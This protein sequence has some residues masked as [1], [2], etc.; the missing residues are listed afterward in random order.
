MGTRLSSSA[1][2]A[3]LWGTQETAA[4]F[5]EKAML[6]TWLDELGALARAQASLGI[7]PSGSA[8]AI[9]AAAKVES[10]DL[11]YVAEQTRATSHSTL[12]LIRGLLRVLPEDVREH[13]YMGATVQDVSDTWFG[14]VMRDVGAVVWRDLRAIEASLLEL[15]RRHRD[16]VMAGRTHGQPGAPITFGFKVAS[17]ADE[18]RRHLDRLRE[19]RPRWVVG[20][21]GG[22]V[23]ALAFFGADGP[24]LRARFCAELGLGDPGISWL[25]SRDRVAEFGTV[26][27]MV[28]GTLSRI[29][30]EV[31]ELARPEIGELAEAAPSGAVSSITMPHKRNPEGSEHLD[32]LARLV[33]SSSAVLVEGMVGGHERDGRS[34]K[35]EW[36]ALPEACQLTA[37]A[38]RLGRGLLDGLEVHTDAM[39]ANVARYGGGLESE[40][41]LA[42]LSAEIGK[43][44]AQ[45]VLH[46]LLREEGTGLTEGLVARG[47]A[48]AE[49]VHAWGHGPAVDA[50]ARMVDVV[51]ER[52]A[53][54]RAAEPEEWA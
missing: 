49:Q 37:T 42:G 27:A 38:L 39:A 41:V 7:V 34:W 22:A 9:T 1:L 19:G 5:D 40:R 51:L 46:E 44:K 50:A 24:E 3:H 13:V 8:A 17:W 54:A 15:A 47:L 32:T 30:T 10:L 23:G 11:D 33:R 16:D 53:V 48:T 12:G 36:I 45:Q 6:Q 4:I 25:T 52:A 31:Y 28:C 35:A 21:L 20:Q 43:H 14:L 26:L 18:V 2:Y 29:G